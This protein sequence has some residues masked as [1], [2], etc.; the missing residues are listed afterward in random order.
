M[1]QDNQT[2]PTQ[3]APVT[4]PTQS[5]VTSVTQIAPDTTAV[6]AEPVQVATP[7]EENVAPTVPGPEPVAVPVN[8]ET[9]VTEPI[10]AVVEQPAQAAVVTEPQPVGVQPTEVKT[11]QN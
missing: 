1:P 10:S 2:Q 6:S 11:V 8:V 5:Q 4:D 9:P 3:Q 7:A